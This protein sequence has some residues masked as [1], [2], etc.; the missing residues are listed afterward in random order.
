[1]RTWRPTEGQ[2]GGRGSTTYRQRLRRWVVVMCVAAAFVLAATLL[3]LAIGLEV[4]VQAGLLVL[5]VAVLPLGLV[6]PALLWLDRYEAEP[7]PYLVFAF[8]W[9]ALIATTLALLLNSG[10]AYL[11]DAGGL[12]AESLAAVA[13]APVV[14]E[15]LKGFAVLAI[16]WWRRHEFDGIVDG[17]VY[18]GMSAAGFA[19]A[20]NIL[21]LGRA[22]LDGGPEGLFALF[23]L[24]GIFS[25]FAH[26]LFTMWFGVGV[27]IAATRR[28]GALRL[29]APLAG[30]ALAI[31]LHALWNLSTFAGVGGFW[32]SYLLLQVPIFAG[33]VAFITWV[34]QREGRL[35]A[36]HLGVYVQFGWFS[37]Q[38]VGMLS[39]L[40]QRRQAR[41]W[42]KDTG[43]RAARATMVAFQD[44]ATELAMLRQRMA[45][46]TA[47]PDEVTQERVLLDSIARCRA[48]LP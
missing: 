10:S 45:H 44:D 40:A 21:Y 22:F 46:G 36:R 11:L 1:M 28:D 48:A 2:G 27:G 4:G 6:I 25:P 43:G 15:S 30:L 16:L 42:A 13:V 9:G 5:G 37:A 20:E 8:A 17:I 32:T 39:S 38:E 12:D 3:S 34:R 35:I 31:A 47:A 7:P 19:L 24:R 41:A 26:P 29:L 23:V 18:A 14:E 33:A